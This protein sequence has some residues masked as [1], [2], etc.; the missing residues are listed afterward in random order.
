MA[1]L[2]VTGHF[3]PQFSG[4]IFSKQGS[5]REQFPT[6]IPS[7]SEGGASRREINNYKLRRKRPVQPQLYQKLAK[8]GYRYGSGAK[9]SVR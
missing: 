4:L 5:A 8:Q 3:S 6:L 7:E 1:S 9:Q 2:S